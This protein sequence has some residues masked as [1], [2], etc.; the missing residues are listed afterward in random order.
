MLEYF[1]YQKGD[2]PLKRQPALSYEHCVSLEKHF[3]KRG[4]NLS[5]LKDGTIV[6]LTMESLQ[7]CKEH[8]FAQKIMQKDKEYDLGFIISEFARHHTLYPAAKM[9]T[10]FSPADYKI[11]QQLG[12]YLLGKKVGWKLDFQ[13]E[14][15]CG[16]TALILENDLVTGWLQAF[17]IITSYSAGDNLL[18][19][20]QYQTVTEFVADQD[21]QICLI[22]FHDQYL[23]VFTQALRI[24]NLTPGQ[25]N[26]LH[27][28]LTIVTPCKVYDHDTVRCLFKKCGFPK[29]AGQIGA[30]KVR[31]DRIN[32]EEIA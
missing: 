3:Q 16:L 31:L 7:R 26:R 18:E 2:Y 15:T 12:M 1:I 22:S 19:R 5:K 17:Y 23:P 4:S 30:R 14:G 24:N 20:L 10:Y 11:L 6:E 28:W 27:D 8:W 9:Q 21:F 25:L 32:E 29:K 13:D